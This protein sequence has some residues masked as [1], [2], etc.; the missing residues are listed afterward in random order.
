VG[1]YVF[2][3]SWGREDDRLAALERQLDPVSQATVGQLGLAAGWRCWEA[4]AGGGSMAVW[5][6]DQVAGR[7]SVLATD[8]D[9]SGLSGLRR[10][11]VTV[12]RH[13]LEREDAPSGKFDLIHARLVL[14]HLREPAAV[15]VKLAAALRAGGWLVLEDADGLR[16]DAEPAH[17]AFAAITGPWQRAALAA[18]WNPCYGRHLVADLQRA[19]LGQVAGRAYRGYQPG[20]PAWLVAR[21]GIERMRDHLQGE[22]ASP[23]D[24]D[25][26]LAALDDPTRT[27]IGAPIVTAWGQRAG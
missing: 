20:G 8:I 15:V 17:P 23:A 1:R 5:L 18:R 27:I 12:A 2:A 21:L 24:L 14:E 26:A 7:G 4:G 3:R 22:G 9:I 13:D 11:N 10:A 19:G 16:F 25:D 6:A